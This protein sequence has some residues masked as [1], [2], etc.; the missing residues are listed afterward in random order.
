MFYTEEDSISIL[1]AWHSQYTMVSYCASLPHG[2]ELCPDGS[3]YI[4]KKKKKANST[5]RYLLF[6]WLSKLKKVKKKMFI[7]DIKSEVCLVCSHY[8]ESRITLWK[9]YFILLNLLSISVKKFL[10][11]L[12]N[13]WSSNTCFHYFTLYYSYKWKWSANIH[14]KTIFVSPTFK[15]WVYIQE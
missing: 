1:S 10:A 14:V 11:S 6:Y 15:S 13:K 5:I 2:E 3:I 4:T 7:I 9:Y 12:M 8:S